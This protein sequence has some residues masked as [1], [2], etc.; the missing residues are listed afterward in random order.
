MKS[1]V[2]TSQPIFT[3]N[4]AWLNGKKLS[5]CALYFSVIIASLFSTSALATYQYTYTGNP[6]TTTFNS[7]ILLPD[8]P[9]AYTT[10]E[11]KEEYIS[12]IFTSESLLSNGSSI[13]DISGFTIS[14]VNADGGRVLPYPYPYPSPNPSGE[15]GTPAHPNYDGIFDIFAVDANGLPTDW[16]ISVDYNYRPPTARLTQTFIKTSTSQDST[17]GGYEGLYDYLGQLNNNPGTWSVTA[18]P[19]PEI[20]AMMLGGLGL[21]GVAIRR[22]KVGSRQPN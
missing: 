4:L 16:N 14:A 18:V 7:L 8:P 12:V 17:Y 20:Y 22:R 11:Y 5:S 15:V 21:I 10:T 13:N 1:F 2:A 19:E 3:S 6:F 9:Y